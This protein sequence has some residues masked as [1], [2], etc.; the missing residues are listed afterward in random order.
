[1]RLPARIQSH[2]VPRRLPARGWQRGAVS[3]GQRTRRVNPEVDKAGRRQILVSNW[4]VHQY[5]IRESEVEVL[6]GH[7][8]HTLVRRDGALKIA[9]KKIVLLN[10]CLPG[11]LDFYNL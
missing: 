11:Q 10:G 2:K 6:F 4:M 1:M 8:R 5:L 7:Y 3:I 9:A